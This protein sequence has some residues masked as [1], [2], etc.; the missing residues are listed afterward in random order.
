MADSSSS[1]SSISQSPSFGKGGGGMGMAPRLPRSI[2]PQALGYRKVLQRPPQPPAAVAQPPAAQP[3]PVPSPVP[4]ATAS[5][6]L[7]E[8]R[9]AVCRACENYRDQ[10]TKVPANAPFCIMKCGAYLE[11]K[12][13]NEAARCCNGKW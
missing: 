7:V 8:K 1:S 12:W 9:K 6:D 5:S 3:Q 13:P 4:P 11:H 2:A 10:N